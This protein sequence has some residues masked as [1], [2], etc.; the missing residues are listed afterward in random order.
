MDLTPWVVEA[1]DAWT[2]ITLALVILGLIAAIIYQVIRPLR[3]TSDGES[4]PGTI[5]SFCLFFWASFLK[6]HTGDG[7]AYQ[8]QMALESFYKSQASV[9][10]ATR[11]RLLRGR[12]EMLAIVAAQLEHRHKTGRRGPNQ[13]NK[14]IWVDVRT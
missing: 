14:P 10:D 2:P 11:K 1:S 12:E 13:P 3:T 9:Y 8:Q 4:S 5:W 7:N 6:P